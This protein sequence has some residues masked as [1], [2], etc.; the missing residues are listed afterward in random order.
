MNYQM[1]LDQFQHLNVF[2]QV[3]FCVTMLV[4]FGTIVGWA[5]TMLR[6]D[7]DKDPKYTQWKDDGKLY[8][9]SKSSPV[10]TPGP[11]KEVT[12]KGVDFS[13]G[14]DH[15]A[16]CK[17]D[18]QGSMEIHH[19]LPD[20]THDFTPVYSLDQTV[21]TEWKKCPEGLLK[22]IKKHCEDYVPDKAEFRVINITNGGLEWQ[23]RGAGSKQQFACFNGD[24]LRK[25]F[26]GQDG[27]LQFL[28]GQGGE[29][30]MVARR[31][32]EI[33]GNVYGFK[34]LNVL[35][36]EQKVKIQ[37]PRL[38]TGQGHPLKSKENMS[39]GDTYIDTLTSDY[40]EKTISGWTKMPSITGPCGPTGFYPGS[41][42]P[43]GDPG[44][45]YNNFLK[46]HTEKMAREIDRQIMSAYVP[47]LWSQK[48]LETMKSN[49]TLRNTAIRKS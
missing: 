39:I 37:I 15:T 1:I 8:R 29:M 35:N 34:V 23:F 28:N 48:M 10:R 38:Y 24:F 18:K 12:I 19:I 45:S 4:S 17:R 36:P 5:W 41:E 49:N 40:Y 7:K 14:K 47:E 11:I 21:K 25:E 22:F 44:F 32:K 27:Y 13:N 9:G 33:E 43:Q 20:K 31:M 3:T 16:V 26:F 46:E 30:A 6:S 2:E 42:G